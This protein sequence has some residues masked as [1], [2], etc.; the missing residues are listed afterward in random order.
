MR[1]DGHQA[2][3]GTRREAGGQ[4]GTS[5]S[6]KQPGCEE[7]SGLGSACGCSWK[8]Q[9]AFGSS[10]PLFSK[11]G[12]CPPHWSSRPS[13]EAPAALG[14]GHSGAITSSHSSPWDAGLEKPLRT[15]WD[16]TSLAKCAST[17]RD[18]GTAEVA[19]DPPPS[20][21]SPLSPPDTFDFEDEVQDNIPSRE[22]IKKQ[23]LQL[24]KMN[25]KRRKKK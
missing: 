23:G 22:D 9:R 10:P 13:W 25:T 4:E 3:A 17:P 16:A 15:L 14:T 6:S 20:P 21:S 19:P 12:L 5:S 24:I 11:Q 7:Q 1:G 8:R 2:T 18:T